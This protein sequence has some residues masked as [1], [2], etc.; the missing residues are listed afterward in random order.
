[1][2]VIE[3]TLQHPW[4]SLSS[5]RV[6]CLCGDPGEGIKPHV[7]LAKFDDGIAGISL[8]APCV[9]SA[10]LHLVFLG[11]ACCLDCCPVTWRLPP[12][13]LYLLCAPLPRQNLHRIQRLTRRA[14]PRP[15]PPSRPRL[16]QPAPL[17]PQ[18]PTPL[19]LRQRASMSCSP[20]VICCSC[21]PKPA[22]SGSTASTATPATVGREQ[23]TPE[24]RGCPSH[25]GGCCTTLGMQASQSLCKSKGDA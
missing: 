12:L 10:C 15:L 24:A 2:L 3:L 6:I 23:R 25:C 1:M 14:P 20:L 7:D 16:G 13:G 17:Q 11:A 9:M 5:L 22:T 19:L 4:M 18:L 8:Q 21:T